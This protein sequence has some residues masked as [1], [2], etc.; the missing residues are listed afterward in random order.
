MGAAS[1]LHLE[2]SDLDAAYIAQRI[3][4]A[5]LPTSVIRVRDRAEF[6]SELRGDRHIDLILSDY[7]LVTFDGM[8]ALDLVREHR[9]NVPFV[10]VSGTL[11]EDVAIETLKKGATDYVLKH[12]LERLVPAIERA[13]AETNERAERRRA[14]QEARAAYER[15]AMAQQAGRA[16][17]FDW[18]IP[19]K[20][21]VWSPE[22]EDL[23]GIPRGTFEQTYAGWARRVVPE[24][25]TVVESILNRSLA[26]R[27]DELEYEFRV[28]LPSGERRWVVGKAKFFR[29]ERGEPVR[30]VG[31]N[32]D[33][34]DRKQAEERLRE[35][36]ERLRLAQTAG[37]MGS[38]EFDP[39]TGIIS[40]TPTCK[41]NFGLPES[42]TVTHELLLKLTHVDDRER[43]TA[44]IQNALKS[45]DDYEIEY[46][47]IRPDG[48]IN[49]IHV[50]GRAVLNADG[51]AVRMVGVSLDVTQRR[52]N[53]DGIR[54]QNERLRILADAAE[55][56]LSADDTSRMVFD[57]FNTVSQRLGLDGYFNFM[58]AED[59][60]AL[61]LDSCAGIPEDAKRGIQRLEFGQAV[62]GTVALTRQPRIATDIQSSADP[63]V[64]LVKSF[65][66]RTYACNPL[67]AGDRLLGTLSFAARDRDRFSE[68]DL[69]VLRTLCHYVAMA[70][71][72]NRLAT[73]ARAQAELLRDQD[74]LKDEFLATL[75]HELRNP[76]APVRAGLG[77]IKMADSRTDR[78][79][80]REMM[81]RQISH[82]VRLVDDL[83]DV[84]RITRGKVELKK[85]HVE[86]RSV[87]DAALEVSRPLIDAANHAFSMNLP[88]GS[89]WLDADPTRLAQVLSNLL[90]NAAKY[91]PKNGHIELI[92]ER[93]GQ[94]VLIRV[95]DNGAGIPRE[96]LPRVFDM[97][98]QIGRTIDR[99]QGGLGIGLTL[100]KRLLELHGGS[101]DVQSPGAGLGSTFTVRLPSLV[102]DGAVSSNSDGVPHTRNKTAHRRVLIVDDS[103]D[104]AESLSLLLSLVG[105]ETKTVHNGKDVIPAAHAF[106]PEIIFLDIGLPGLNGYEVA[107]LIRRD[108]LLKHTLI[109]ALTGWGSESDRRRS[110]DAGFDHHL[111]KP[112]DSKQLQ[113]IFDTLLQ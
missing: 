46:R 76:L 65:G 10:F 89:L 28:L 99:S 44:Q 84:S 14:E 49:W 19:E 43:V 81:E 73:E 88:N 54:R 33:I 108:P 8:E 113:L 66:F 1:I 91:T 23:Y 83:L 50:R 7:Q 80:A 61:R 16:G 85:E 53:E 47:N 104:G 55:R 45:G 34:H 59:G 112:V 2:D 51:K 97:F 64:Q 56:L 69:E 12:R 13:L 96:M 70:K 107:A 30:M 57:L 82:M 15:L 6:V 40:C 20:R 41:M 90:N 21:V 38:W 109:V 102:R 78:D 86:L 52:R 110:Q 72:R 5:G 39:A 101:I 100:V 27:R 67:L 93:D 106:R 37:N 25:V 42:A 4:R 48:S 32:I 111:T 74:R 87:V 103:V 94:E 11:G 62:C 22:L 29:D 95:R 98:T 63:L 26:D 9:P 75:A 36:E 17:M 92:A 31:I 105:H 68:E 18:N 79:R 35:S 58:V 71:E 24:D 77:I 60:T 3:Q